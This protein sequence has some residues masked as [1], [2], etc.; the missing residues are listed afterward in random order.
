[1]TALAADTLIGIDD[2]DG[3]PTWLLAEGEPVVAGPPRPDRLGV[4]HRCET[5]LV[6]VDGLGAR[7]WCKLARGPTRPTTR[8]PGARCAA[9]PPALAVLGGHPATPRLRWTPPR[10]TFRRRHSTTST[11]PRWPTSSTPPA[12][13]SRSSARCSPARCCPA[14]RM[15]HVAGLAHLDVKPENVVVRDGVPMLLDFGSVREIGTAAGRSPGRHPGLRGA[16]MEACRPI[17]AADGPVGLGATMAEALTGEPYGPATEVPDSIVA[18]LVH[19]LLDDDPGRRGTTDGV[20]GALARAVPEA[21]RPWPAWPTR[22]AAQ[23]QGLDDR[24]ALAH[25]LN[26][27]GQLRP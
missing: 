23:V 20:L 4:G 17:S 1:M 8:V 16:E 22:S 27:Q 13:S 5:W 25:H 3:L 11:A 14:L 26:G 15:L 7:W 10:R 12:R 19:R 24:L 9:R 18:P 2:E 6:L 21:L